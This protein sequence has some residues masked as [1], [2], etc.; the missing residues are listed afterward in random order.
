MAVKK[1]RKTAKSSP[2]AKP[3]RKAAPAKAAHAKA[4]AARKTSAKPHAPA[5]KRPKLTLKPGGKALPKTKPEIHKVQA[6][7][8][9]AKAKP[10]K[11]AKN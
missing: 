3:V 10:G 7:A 1:A 9:P 6:K 2:K 4:A 8:E 11:A 5:G